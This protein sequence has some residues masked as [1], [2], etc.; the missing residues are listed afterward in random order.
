MF[1]LALLDQLFYRS[2]HVFNWHVGIDAVLIQQ[3]DAVRLEPLERSLGNFLDVV[4][5]A[6]G[7][8]GF[9]GRRIDLESEL[10]CDYH[11]I[12]KWSQRFA[13][14]LFIDKWPIDFSSIKECDAAFNGRPNQRDSFL[15]VHGGTQTKT[16]AHAT[17]PDG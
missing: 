16:H 15:L 1:H 4:G 7:S 13:H 9:A 3:V 12:A 14:E 10:R 8:H 6:V 2:R 5:T 17:K 11:L